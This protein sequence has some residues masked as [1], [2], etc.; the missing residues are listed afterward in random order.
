MQNILNKN[1]LKKKV[2]IKEFLQLIGA[3]LIFAL[4]FSNLIELMKQY[5]TTKAAPA[6]K[7]NLNVSHG[8]GSTKF[9][10]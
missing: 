9:G 8:F 3:S 4:G 2:T 5:G 7:Q 10:I 1:I 6:V